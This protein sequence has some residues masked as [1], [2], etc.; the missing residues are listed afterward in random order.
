M[1]RRFLG[2]GLSVFSR[3]WHVAGNPYKIVHDSQTL[4]KKFFVGLKIGKMAQKCARNRVFW[5]YW[6][7]LSLIFTQFVLQWKVILFAEFLHKSHI[8]RS[9]GPKC[10]QI[11]G[12]F[13]S[14]ISLEQIYKMVRFFAY[15]CKF[16]KIKSWLKN[17][18]MDMNKNGRG[19][20]G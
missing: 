7:I 1:S 19:Q 10:S 14:A 13:I 11:A 18:W 3:F 17:W 5:I 20:G 16:T 4:K 15:W 9:L 2:I 12:I 8:W 6:K